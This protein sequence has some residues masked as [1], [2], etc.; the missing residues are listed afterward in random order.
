MGKI[1]LSDAR[2]AYLLIF[3]L[4]FVGIFSPV[5]FPMPVSEPVV[6]A[7]EAVEALPDGSNVYVWWDGTASTIKCIFGAQDT[8]LTHLF[9][10]DL[11]VILW[12]H[13]ANTLLLGDNAIR[14]V[15]GLAS[16]AD[17]PDYGTKFVDLGYIPGTREL[18]WH[19]LAD[20]VRGIITVDRYG[21]PLDDLPLMA[22]IMDGSDIDFVFQSGAT[23]SPFCIEAVMNSHRIPYGVGYVLVGEP[24]TL[25][26][27]ANYYATGYCDGYLAGAAGGLQYELVSGLPGIGAKFGTAS[28]LIT[29]F[30]IVGLV[31]M[32][33]RNLIVPPKEE[34]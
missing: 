4:T 26:Y 14:R 10:K 19:A 2:Y 18:V 11:N 13:D 8:V 16:T 30:V 29:L 21:T 34:T 1:D 28:V 5:G 27:A 3:V 33:V 22:G 17:H 20:E 6:T 9:A 32:N 23:G 7:Y 12:T 15:L 31:V 24:E 25:V